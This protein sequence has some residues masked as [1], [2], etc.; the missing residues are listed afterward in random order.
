MRTGRVSVLSYNI[1][2]DSTRWSK[3]VDAILIANAD[4]VC[5]QE[6]STACFDHLRR[7]LQHRYPVKLYRDSNYGFGGLAFFSKYK[8]RDQDYLPAEHDAWFPAWIVEADTPAGPVQILQVHLRP[9]IADVGG[10]VIGHLTVGSIHR[11]EVA[12]YFDRL[13]TGV[14]TLIVGDFNEENGAPA[15]RFLRK[16]DFTNALPLFDQD[17][18]TWQ[19]KVWGVKIK[20]RID[21]IFFSTHFDCTEARVIHGGGSDHLPIRAAFMQRAANS[22]STEE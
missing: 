2:A 8:I 19:G 3:T 20:S 15:V 14:P 11:R 10:K 6:V 16:H 17:S 7:E 9:R 12:A 21:H 1:Q 4:V 22:S 13:A 18:H 5:L